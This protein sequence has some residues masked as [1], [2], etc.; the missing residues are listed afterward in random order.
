M[1]NVRFGHFEWIILLPYY[2]YGLKIIEDSR[3]FEIYCLFTWY[4]WLNLTA[5][6]VEVSE[7]FSIEQLWFRII[8]GLF[9]RCS[10]PQNRWRALIQLWTAL[11]TETFRAKNQRWN[12]ADF[13]WNRLDSELNSA[14]FLWNSSETGNFQSKKSAL[15]QSCF[16]ADFLWNSWTALIFSET[17]LKNQKSRAKKSAL[18]Q[19]CFSADFSWNRADTTGAFLNSSHHSWFSPETTLNI[20]EI[21]VF[22]FLSSADFWQFF[23]GLSDLKLSGNLYFSVFSQIS[24]GKLGSYF[25]WKFRKYS[26]MAKLDLVLFQ[27]IFSRKPQILSSL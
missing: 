19:C 6:R 14:D 7:K 8:S 11:K 22:Q 23:S 26:V 13:L 10:L 3:I 2:K 17:A 24:T 27:Q 5:T 1:K 12:S 25:C 15:N 20:P 21:C 18:N 4:V 9:Q 16:S